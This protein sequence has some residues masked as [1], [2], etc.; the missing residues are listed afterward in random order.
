MSHSFSALLRGNSPLIYFA[1]AVSKPSGNF[2]F[3]LPNLTPLAFADAMPSACLT[4]IMISRQN[5]A[6]HRILKAK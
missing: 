3:S 6:I 4:F 5:Q 2:A 1:F